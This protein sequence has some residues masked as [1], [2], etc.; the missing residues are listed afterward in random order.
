MEHEKDAVGRRSFLK[1]GLGV[2]LGTAALISSATAHA[3]S[4]PAKNTKTEGYDTVVVGAGC[5]GLACA[6][7]A[8][9]RG[10]KV[11]LLEKMDRPDGNTIYSSGRFAG[12][13]SRFQKDTGEN[14]DEFV[15]DMLHLSHNRGDANLLRAYAELSGESIDW[16][17]DL[18]VP[19]K[20]VKN[21][22]HPS[23]SRCFFLNGNGITGGSVLMRVLLA[24]AKQRNIPIHYNTKAFELIT[25]ENKAVTG[26]FTLTDRGPKNYMA[27]GGVVLTTGGFSANPEMVD[28]YMGDWATRLAVRGSLCTTG[29][30]ILMTKPLHALLVNM[31]QFYAGPI[32]PETHANP[33]RIGNSAYGII[34]SLQGKRFL[35]ENLEQAPRSKKIA[36]ATPDNR[37][38]IIVDAKTDDEDMILSKLLKR[39]GRLN[40]PIAK[41]NTLEEMI[42]A[43]GLPM[44][45]TL[46]TIKEFNAAVA[47]G[48]T[49]QLDPPQTRKKPHPIATA[50]FYAVPM[51]GGIA[52][53][54]G[55]PKIDTSARI[56]NFERRPIPGL[57]A[58]GNAAG[59]VWY[60]AD[61]G[62]N[63]L[64]SGLVFGRI[65]ARDSAARAKGKKA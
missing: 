65:A 30:N 37:S 42:K 63:Q 53:T 12:V 62:G 7:E 21:L 9:D 51:S 40:S 25:D 16:L 26:V 8:H 43:A 23:G 1:G 52:A 59:G 15:K 29:E 6:I 49:A 27:K 19:L 61:I 11:V 60:E 45:A 56:V 47:A 54:F 55:G 41:G 44:E 2:G 32:V 18:G 35:D 28:I 46:A 57:Y 3:Q 34:V 24:A 20:L 31:D 58:A 64:A 48:T 17:I 4:A 38:F 33:A 14:V 13:G 39:F 50:P 10:A 36:Q 22:P 5:A